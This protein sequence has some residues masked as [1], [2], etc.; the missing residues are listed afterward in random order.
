MVAGYEIITSD[1]RSG[2][3]Y[4]SSGKIDPMFGIYNGGLIG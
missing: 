2:S 1:S 3:L 4:H